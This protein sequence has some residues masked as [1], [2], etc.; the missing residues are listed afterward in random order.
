MTKAT[1]TKL[2]LVT[3]ASSGIG[4]AV[5][6]ALLKAG[7]E[8]IGVSRNISTQTIDHPRFSG[9]DMDLSNISQI[10]HD[11]KKL[12]AL[13]QQKGGFL[14]TVF[15]AGAG[16]FGFLEQ[17]STQQI[18]DQIDLNLTSQI[19]LTK[20]LI[21][22]FKQQNSAILIYMGSEAALRGGRQGTIYCASKFGLRGFVQ[23]LNEE[24]GTSGVRA[25]I[26]NPGMVNTPFFDG[27]HFQPG[28]NEMNSIDPNTIGGLVAHLVDA[29]IETVVDEVTLSP[30]KKVI[31]KK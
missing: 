18:R 16:K 10:E 23:A 11:A 27:L 9:F 25:T 29:P 30:R 20:Q 12:K 4:R 6:Y 3:G 2:F 15:C 5:S 14:G 22:Q 21:N 19:V 17:L 8:V 28:E 31:L 26:I 7:H 13:G 1:E 24:C